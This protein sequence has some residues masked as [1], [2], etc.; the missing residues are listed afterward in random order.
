MSTSL[1][2][3]PDG[4]REAFISIKVICS[5]GATSLTLKALSSSARAECFICGEFGYYKRLWNARFI[6]E[7]LGYD[8]KRAARRKWRPRL[9]AS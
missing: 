1:L 7:T 4:R 8:K 2:S 3:V 6:T 5:C 9:P